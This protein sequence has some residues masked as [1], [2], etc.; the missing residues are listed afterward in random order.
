MSGTGGHDRGWH[1]DDTIDVMILIDRSEI[2]QPLTEEWPPS[3]FLDHFVIELHKQLEVLENR[4]TLVVESSEL[5]DD[6]DY[7]S[8][9]YGVVTNVPSAARWT[10]GWSGNLIELERR[11]ESLVLIG[12]ETR[13]F[14]R[15]HLSDA[16]GL[17]AA[18][19]TGCT[20]NLP[21]SA[22]R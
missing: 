13:V 19:W 7:P 21:T 3:D 2:G 11:G 15:A 18:S 20:M 5:P 17:R 16:L 22:S 9:I 6:S 12:R 8:N 4:A 10:H 1:Q 14:D